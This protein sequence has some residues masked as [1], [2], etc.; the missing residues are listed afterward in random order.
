MEEIKATPFRI[1]IVV[2]HMEYDDFIKDF[3]QENRNDIGRNIFGYPDI[4]KCKNFTIVVLGDGTIIYIIPFSIYACKGRRC[5]QLFV[6]QK[7]F[8]TYMNAISTVFL[9]CLVNFPYDMS[10]EFRLQLIE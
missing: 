4:R 8:N 6:T 5:H 2:T 10:E 3:V 1:I 7:A 9:P